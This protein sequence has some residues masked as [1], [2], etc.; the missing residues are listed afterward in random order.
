MTTSDTSVETIMVLKQLKI[1]RREV[2][3]SRD[4]MEKQAKESAIALAVTISVSRSRTRSNFFV[5][6]LV[7]KF[8]MF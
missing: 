8:C 5:N 3:E 2:R 1:L 6:V 4:E 7:V